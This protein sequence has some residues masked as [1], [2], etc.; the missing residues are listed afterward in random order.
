VRLR[1]VSVRVWHLR[2]GRLDQA[3]VGTSGHV[4]DEHADALR[5]LRVRM[6]LFS[7]GGSAATVCVALAM[8]TTVISNPSAPTWLRRWRSGL[9]LPG[10]ATRS[11]TSPLGGSHTVRRAGRTVLSGT[12]RSPAARAEV[13]DR[14]GRLPNHPVPPLTQRDEDRAAANATTCCPSRKQE[15]R[16]RHCASQ[17]C[18]GRRP[19]WTTVGRTTTPSQP[20]RRVRTSLPTYAPR[21]PASTACR[22]RG[23]SGHAQDRRADRS[24]IAKGPSDGSG[25]RARTR[26][27]SA[28]RTATALVRIIEK[29]PRRLT[30]YLATSHRAHR[31]PCRLAP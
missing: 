8:A 2:F 5:W 1:I 17:S 30:H 3:L 6:I 18:L 24:R 31:R 22:W 23:S 7:L 19:R 27:A 20:S 13:R 26:T 16:R 10:S 28:G 21:Q 29:G 9:P 25:S 4:T 11:R 12:F 14:S 15:S